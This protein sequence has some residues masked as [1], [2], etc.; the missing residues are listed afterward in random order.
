MGLP[1]LQKCVFLALK[2]TT[3]LAKKDKET[4]VSKNLIWE[5]RYFSRRFS[6]FI[7]FI[8]YFFP[9]IFS[10]FLL[11]FC[12]VSYIFSGQTSCS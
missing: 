4:R 1:N 7:L 3:F 9:F 12:T 11:F 2:K 5:V 6:C 10:S 8:K